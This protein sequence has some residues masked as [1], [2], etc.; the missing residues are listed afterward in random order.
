M[1]RCKLG[2][3]TSAKDRTK[4]AVLGTLFGTVLFLA[5]RHILGRLTEKS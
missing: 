1:E 2:F 5:G 3:P 4:F